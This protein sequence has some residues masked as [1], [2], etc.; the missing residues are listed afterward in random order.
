[1]YEMRQRFSHHGKFNK[2]KNFKNKNKIKWKFNTKI[3]IEKMFSNF[4]GCEALGSY[5][6]MKNSMM[7]HHHGHGHDHDHRLLGEKDDHAH[8]HKKDETTAVEEVVA[9]D[10]AAFIAGVCMGDL[11]KSLYTTDSGEK[12]RCPPGYF[13]QGVD[14][15]N[16]CSGNV[17][18]SGF[19]WLACGTLYIF[20]S[21]LKSLLKKMFF[22]FVAGLL[23]S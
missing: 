17:F 20:H 9:W 12:K 1:M 22:D 4:V 23:L 5:V 10:E 18:A 3:K 8:H 11:S 7:D 15:C 13:G 6:C 14:C 16:K 21:Y 2:S 19:A